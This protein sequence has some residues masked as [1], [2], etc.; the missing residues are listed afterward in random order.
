MKGLVL[1]ILLL[2]CFVDTKAQDNIIRGTIKAESGIPVTQATVT[3]RSKPSD[4]AIGFSTSDEH[5]KFTIKVKAGY[6]PTDIQLMISHLSY[7]PKTLNLLPDVWQYEI[8]LEESTVALESVEIKSRPRVALQGDTIN[9]HVDRFARNEDR[10][11]GD[12]LSRIPGIDVGESGEI[13]F[14]NRPISHFYLD[15]DDLLGGKYA[16]GTRTIP[17]DMVDKV[18]VLTNHE[19]IKVRKDRFQSEGVA[20]N[21]QIKEDARLKLVGIA[22]LGAGLSSKYDPEVN[23]ILLNRDFKMLNSA[24]GNNVGEDLS[25]DVF[26]LL[27][28][29][30]ANNG[31]VSSSAVSTPFIARKRYFLNHSGMATAN[32]S[33]RF[34]NELFVRSNLNYLVQ[35][36]RLMFSGINKVYV[37][38]DT[39]TFFE[40]QNG[41]NLTQSSAV[42]LFAEMNKST[43]YIKNDLRL[44]YDWGRIQSDMSNNATGFNQHL[45]NRGHRFSNQMQYIP[46]LKNKDIVHVSWNLDVN[47]GPQYLRFNPGIFPEIIYAGNPYL[48]LDQYSNV[49]SWSSRLQTSYRVS[50]RG[51]IG[52]DYGASFHNRHQSLSSAI[53]LVDGSHNSIPYLNGE[54]DNALSWDEYNARVYAGYRHKKDRFQ[55]E[56]GLPLIFSH[57]TYQDSGFK[58]KKANTYWLIEPYV[59]M[60]YQLNTHDRISASYRMDNSVND[61]TSLYQGYIFT[62]YRTFQRNELFNLW[63]Q[64]SHNWQMGYHF[65]RPL[66]LFFANI[67]V[68]YNLTNRHVLHTTH[69]EDN[70]QKQVQIPLANQVKMMGANMVFSK[71]IFFLGTTLAIKPK[72]SNLQMEES[73]NDVLYHIDNNNYTVSTSMD[74]QVF[75]KISVTHNLEMTHS[76]NSFR[77]TSDNNF[78]SVS[79]NL[80]RNNLSLTYS[81]LDHLHLKAYAQSVHVQQGEVLD[82]DMYF[83]DIS[84]KWKINHLRSDLELYISNIANHKNFDTFSVRNNG[85]VYNQFALNPRMVILKYVF[86]F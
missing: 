75:R 73:F 1:I 15:G 78:S 38:R 5:G 53:S 50:N 76:K 62:N 27:N 29:H 41:K 54:N 47:D 58:Q 9:Y 26:D 22:K 35:N 37:E 49:A 70:M 56:W 42:D 12:V 21:L 59:N 16:I 82:V 2:F 81:P 48:Q 3:L 33:H 25:I 24:K 84:T 79:N 11:I 74:F 61:I 36:N 67:G 28:N 64:N 17:H 57:I 65:K 43:Y 18:Q 46:A 60:Q 80:V 32:N 10:T 63:S 68:N 77:Q 66:S 19:H 20:L 39:V 31:L 23:T 8:V 40:D 30:S 45:M 34:R 72:W 52:Q 85:F 69:F 6:H 51:V 83:V 71:Y 44:K 14:N 7:K 55:A 4:L 13:R 86:N